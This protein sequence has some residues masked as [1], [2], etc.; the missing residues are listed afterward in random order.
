MSSSNWKP[1][2]GQPENR[3]K[4]F[5]TVRELEKTKTEAV[6]DLTVRVLVRTVFLVPRCALPA[7][8]SGGESSLGL[9]SQDTN[10]THEVSALMAQSP[11][12]LHLQT[13]SHQ[14]LSFNIWMLRGTNIQC[15]AVMFG[16]HSLKEF[17]NECLKSVWWTV[18]FRECLGYKNLA[19]APKGGQ[20]WKI[21]QAPESPLSWPRSSPGWRETQLLGPPVLSPSPAVHRHGP[22]S[23]PN[24][25][26]THNLIQF[27]GSVPKPAPS[28]TWTHQCSFLKY[29]PDFRFSSSQLKPWSKH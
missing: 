26:R 12:K 29:E 6:A 19:P 24:H 11:R 4:A 2:T 3:R 15:I 13:R 14:D 22:K 8:S 7:V 28:G 23:T 21:V 27:H 25:L 17:K 16:D 1:R 10:S 18:S 20:F 9:F 5:L